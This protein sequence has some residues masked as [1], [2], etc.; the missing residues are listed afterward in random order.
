LEE[1]PESAE[2]K[3]GLRLLEKRVGEIDA[4]LKRELQNQAGLK[5]RT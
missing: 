1:D 3:S 5:N 2:A 4:A